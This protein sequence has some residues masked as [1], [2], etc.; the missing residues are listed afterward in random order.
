MIT[1]PPVHEFG[2]PEVDAHLV[3]RPDGWEVV[4]KMTVAL[5]DEA[6]RVELIPLTP[7][8]QISVCVDQNHHELL[9]SKL[10]DSLPRQFEVWTGITCFAIGR[11]HRCMHLKHLLHCTRD[12]A[13]LVE[14]THVKP[15]RGADSGRPA[16]LH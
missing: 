7:P 13:R 6:F 4:T 15:V 5:G 16:G 3:P 11:E 10:K 12:V 14:G 8:R 2:M 9:S 1:A